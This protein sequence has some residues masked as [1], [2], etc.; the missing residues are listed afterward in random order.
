[1][2][3]TEAYRMYRS[4]GF[5]PKQA[6]NRRNRGP[7]KV[8]KDYYRYLKNPPQR[9]TFKIY[10]PSMVPSKRNIQKLTKSLGKIPQ[11]TMTQILASNDYLKIKTSIKRFKGLRA[12]ANKTKYF[13]YEII[14]SRL[15]EFD[16][17]DFW[18]F[19]GDIYEISV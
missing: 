8:A 15:E 18:D 5:T 4:A 6:R 2:N 3:R 13:R 17:A 9:A 1:M 10:R 11:K 16:E 14:E 19:L 12:H 7:E